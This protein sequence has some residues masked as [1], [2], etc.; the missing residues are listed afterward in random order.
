MVTHFTRSTKFRHFQM[1]PHRL[2]DGLAIL[3]LVALVRVVAYL[4][5]P[6]SAE[7]HQSQAPATR[8]A[9]QRAGSFD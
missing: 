3:I 1:N 7:P 8:A 6:R 5:R 9:P 2:L 4:G